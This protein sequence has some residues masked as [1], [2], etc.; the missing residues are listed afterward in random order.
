MS[1]Y[2]LAEPLHLALFFSVI[3]F[4]AALLTG[5]W[6]WRAML[7]SGNGRAH[8]YIDIA[9]HAA[10]HYGPF[11][12]LAGALASFWPFGETLPAWTLI[13][14]MGG[15]MVLSLSRYVSLGIRGT[16]KNQLY[17]ATPSARLGLFFFFFGSVLPG[18]MIA[19]G[20]AIS[21]WAGLPG[22]PF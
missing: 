22:R 17:K 1:F 6:K 7:A 14:V 12:V 5:V 8:S 18:L 13:A 20:A 10:L 16:I 3:Y 4:A 11:I 9:H 21:L 19:F 15:T 2:P